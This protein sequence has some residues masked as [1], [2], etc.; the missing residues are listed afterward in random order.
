MPPISD[1]KQ[2]DVILVLSRATQRH[3]LSEESKYRE[4]DQV[5]E[6]FYVAS[7]VSPTTALLDMSFKAFFSL[8]GKIVLEV[9]S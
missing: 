9:R 3:V 1:L 2:L 7:Q 6:V 8:L 4:I 5:Q